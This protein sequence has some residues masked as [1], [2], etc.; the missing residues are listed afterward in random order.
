MEHD[1]LAT[2]D[3]IIVRYEK[4]KVQRFQKEIDHITTG[5]IDFRNSLCLQTT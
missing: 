5:E 3:Q 4:I 1:S 2:C